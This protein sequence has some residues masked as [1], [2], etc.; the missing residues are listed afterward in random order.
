MA[1]LVDES[2]LTLSGAIGISAIQRALSNGSGTERRGKPRIKE[3]FPCTAWGSDSIGRPFQLDCVLDN[4]SSSG[5]YLHLP[6]SVVHGDDLSLVVNFDRRG[7]SGAKALLR[8]RVNRV[9]AQ[10]DG[11]TGVA[12]IVTSYQFL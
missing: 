2:E 6:L 9:E 12:L 10:T 1:S 8:C 5:A 4:L 3:S 11:A 7:G